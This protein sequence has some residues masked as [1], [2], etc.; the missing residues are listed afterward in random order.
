MI[1]SPPTLT[2]AIQNGLAYLKQSQRPSGEFTTY[3]G[4][5]LD[6]G[7]SMPA[8]KSVYITTFVIHSLS[9]LPPDPVIPPLQ[10]GA[11]AFLEAEQEEDGS[12]NYDGRGNTKFP[13]DLDDTG[14]VVA[15][16]LKLGRRPDLSFYALLWQNEAA[17]G[18]PYYTWIGAINRLPDDSDIRTRQVDS[19]V[20]ANILFCCGLLDLALPGVTAYI[21]QVVRDEGYVSQSLYCIGPHFPIYTI[22]RAQADGNVAALAPVMPILQNY[23]LTQLAPPQAE[24]SALNLAC[25]ANSLL[26][27]NAPLSLVEPY[28]EALL[29]AQR[30]DGGW[31]AWAAYVGYISKYDGSPALTT[32][33]ALEAVGKYLR[34]WG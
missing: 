34:E 21:R 32:A 23:I 19:L 10:K 17:P 28:L 18:G 22:S 25:L 14:C 8:P 16:R 31:P 2:T 15:A 12:W 3:T 26:N 5:E 11:A 24:P 9:Y 20:N 29:A 1:L 30:P 7:E 27:L 4:P 6:L 33:L 13:A